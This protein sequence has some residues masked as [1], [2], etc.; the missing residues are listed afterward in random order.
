MCSWVGG[1]GRG[2]GL[3]AVDVGYHLVGTVDASVVDLPPLADPGVGGVEAEHD[4]LAHLR[5]QSLVGAQHVVGSGCE[6]SSIKN[7]SDMPLLTSSPPLLF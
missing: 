4:E 7:W 6:C 1:V 5:G 2:R 3:H